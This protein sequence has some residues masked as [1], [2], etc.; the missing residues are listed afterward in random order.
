MAKKKVPVTISR[1]GQMPEELMKANIDR[2]RNEVGLAPIKLDELPDAF[3]DF[4]AGE[5]KGRYLKS[6]GA[7]KV[8]LVVMFN[9]GGASWFFKCSATP[10]SC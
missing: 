6:K 10:I 7:E 5:I 3:A 8:S 2:W 4:Q 9:Q 1:M